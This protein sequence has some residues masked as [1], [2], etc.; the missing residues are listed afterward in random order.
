M[1]AVLQ[2]MAMVS[3]VGRP[4]WLPTVAQEYHSGVYILRDGPTSLKSVFYPLDELSP[5]VSIFC[6]SL[7]LWAVHLCPIDISLK[8]CPSSVFLFSFYQPLLFPM[9]V[10]SIA[11]WSPPSS[12]SRF[13]SFGYLFFSLPSSFCLIVSRYIFSPTHFTLN[14][15]DCA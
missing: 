15:M 8:H 7:P 6:L 5:S 3:E 9:C 12:S 14:T 13:S 2:T 1:M 11:F 4:Y 10:L